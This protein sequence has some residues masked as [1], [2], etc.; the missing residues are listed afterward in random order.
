MLMVS[1]ISADADAARAL[2]APAVPERRSHRYGFA[3]PLNHSHGRQDQTLG[4]SP[5]PSGQASTPHP[6]G[7][8]PGR[9]IPHICFPD[10]IHL[11]G[12][13]NPHGD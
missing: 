10:Q 6:P 7:A 2:R 12:K 13:A 1:G 11:F 4:A 9:P 8:Q 3:A 5:R